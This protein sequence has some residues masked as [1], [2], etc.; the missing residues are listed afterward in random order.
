MKLQH[1]LIACAGAALL[2]GCEDYYAGGY[3][4][5]YYGPGY[6][7]PEYAP[8]Y[9][10]DTGYYGPADLEY[11]AYYDGYYGPIYDGYWRTGSFYYRTSPTGGFRQGGAAHFR[12]APAAGFNHVHGMAHAAPGA[13]TTRPPG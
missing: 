13:R 7:G 4:P 9:G 12:S 8:A 10:Y 11:D 5:D 2:A 1:V 3:G 6:Y